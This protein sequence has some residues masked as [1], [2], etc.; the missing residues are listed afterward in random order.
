MAIPSLPIVRRRILAARRSLAVLD[1][2]LKRLARSLGLAKSARTHR[3]RS[4][5][6]PKARAALKLQG[7]YMGYMRQLKPMQKAL[8][9]AVLAKRGK[10]AAIKKARELAEKRK[11]A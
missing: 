2:S 1:R 10:R 9:R 4:T 7:R 5:L 11:A 8:V 6:S 3:R